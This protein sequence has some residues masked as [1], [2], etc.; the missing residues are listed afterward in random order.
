MFMFAMTHR[1][2]DWATVRAEFERGTTFRALAERHGVSIGT[3]H[4]RAKGEGWARRRRARAGGRPAS[5]RAAAK[6]AARTVR[7]PADAS[8]D[9]RAFL[10]AV[11]G[12]ADVALKIR[13]DAAKALLRLEP[14]GLAG[15][16][17][18]A[19]AEAER[20]AEE[21]DDEWGDDLRLR[22]H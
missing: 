4:K 10:A 19:A 11:M 12:A 7:L 22:C 16:K 14:S 5:A 9:P 15:K 13:V 3:L 21:P 18:R 6:K 17:A 20:V 1:G 2:I 8:A